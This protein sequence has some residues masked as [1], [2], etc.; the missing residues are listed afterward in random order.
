MAVGHTD[1]VLG[2]LDGTHVLIAAVDAVDA[3]DLLREHQSQRLDIR[4]R[5]VVL[6]ELR[7]SV[8]AEEAD[9]L[10]RRAERQVGVECRVLL[11]DRTLDDDVKRTLGHIASWAGRCEEPLDYSVCIIA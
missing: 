11:A 9:R 10:R 6:A 8:V 5:V 1:R 3:A 2:D 4:F 7:P